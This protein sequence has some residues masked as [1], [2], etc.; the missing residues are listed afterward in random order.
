MPLVKSKVKSTKFV[1]CWFA[2]DM[3]LSPS[4]L[5]MRTRSFHALS[6]S[7]RGGKGRCSS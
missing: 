4:S 5:N 7:R 2:C 6:L 3:I 1:C